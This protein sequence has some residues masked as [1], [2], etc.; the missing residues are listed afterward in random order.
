ML[1]HT[2]AIAMLFTFTMPALAQDEVLVWSGGVGVE[3][4]DSA[5]KEGT[6]LVFFVES[7]N[8]LS[9]V[10]VSVKDSGGREVVNA[11]S[12]GPWMILN[13][14]AG[15]YHVRASVGEQAQ[16]GT[17]DVVDGGKKEFA[18]MFKAQ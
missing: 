11:V 16:G 4:R 17:I 1:K 3:E 14:P 15:R 7:G 13:L 12:K 9:G 18:Y 5:P 8:F 2:L 10:K 6:K